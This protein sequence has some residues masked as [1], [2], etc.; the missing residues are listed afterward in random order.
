MATAK[1]ILGSFVILVALSIASAQAFTVDPAEQNR[2]SVIR[3]RGPGFGNNPGKVA[4]GGIPAP[5]AHWDDNLIECYVPEAAAL[6]AN[7]VQVMPPRHTGPK[8]KARMTVLPRETFTGRI[9]WRL[10]LPDQYVTTRPIV[11]ADG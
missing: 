8:M 9:K 6:G 4:V 7:K 10:K 5:I 1:S 11:G 2:S 3:L